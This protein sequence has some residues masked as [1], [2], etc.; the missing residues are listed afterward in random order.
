MA[1]IKCPEC[2]GP[3]SD[4]STKCP[5]C[6]YDIQKYVV[7]QQQKVDDAI[8]CAVAKQESE[9]QQRLKTIDNMNIPNAPKLKISWVTIAF[10]C[11]GILILF[12]L[13]IGN[14]A[15]PGWTWVV[16]LISLGLGFGFLYTDVSDYSTAK[17]KHQEIILDFD[18]HKAMLKKVAIEQSEHYITDLKSR[19]EFALSLAGIHT[20]EIQPKIDASLP[21]CPT[22]GSTDLTKLSVGTR[23]IDGF[24]YGQL[25][26][27]GR[28]QFRCNKCGYKW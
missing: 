26:V 6:G 24:V 20:G 27:E 14:G 13:L 25:S 21:K 7:K 10:L 19:D 11:F 28:A 9:L 16:L 5:H 22:C 4:T 1:L 8:A 3:V 18:G 12:L 17:R 2:H 15:T 23:A